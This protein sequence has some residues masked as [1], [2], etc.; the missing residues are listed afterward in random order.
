MSFEYKDELKE[1][2]PEY[3]KLLEEQDKTE[4][5]GDD[6]W[7]CPYC[8]SGDK[9]NFTAA[10]HIDGR[11]RF[12]CFSCGEHGDIFD[13]VGYIEELPD[14]FKKNYNRA[15]K[16]M[17]PYLE[18]NKTKSVDKSVCVPEIP[19][20][21]DYTDYLQQCHKNVGH[22]DYFRKR[23][24]SKQTI[25]RFRLGYDINKKVITIPYNLDCK[26]YVHRILWN[27]DNKYCKFGNEIFNV[28]ALYSGAS[29]YVFVTEGQ[30]DA[31]SYEEIGFPAIGL[32]GVNEVTK[33]VSQLKG[34]PSSKIL[35]LAMDNDK[36]GR[37]ATGSF[38]EEIA[39]NEL[40][41][42]FIVDSSLYG[43]YKD[44]NEFL[45]ADREGFKERV[46][47]IS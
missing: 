22:I 45:V 40:D 38:I 46:S 34:H 21:K 14:D 25:T 10:F 18:G 42:K 7:V 28:D 8:G 2:L 31:M 12:N 4:N 29:N 36:A 11:T 20:I 16:I 24:L 30:I 32:G 39:E 44:A 37:R 23:G 33:L 1:L 15:L 5:R 47:L 3:M 9:K 13:L 17:R 43:K 27:G 19:K 41:Q 6:Y 26:G 35:I